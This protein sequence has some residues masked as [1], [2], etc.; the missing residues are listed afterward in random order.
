MQQLRMPRSDTWDRGDTLSRV[1]GRAAYQQSITTSVAAI[2]SEVG[3]GFVRQNN[4]S[5]FGLIW[6]RTVVQARV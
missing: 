4:L 2:A 1:I 5:V 3:P 6:N